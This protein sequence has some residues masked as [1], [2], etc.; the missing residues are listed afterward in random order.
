[1]RPCLSDDVLVLHALGGWLDQRHPAHVHEGATPQA[2]VLQQGLH[3]GDAVVRILEKRVELLRRDTPH[4]ERRA[5][6]I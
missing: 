1:M 2:A 6:A 4:T 3:E 5:C